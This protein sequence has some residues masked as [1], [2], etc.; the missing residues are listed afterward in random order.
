[1]ALAAKGR[2]LSAGVLLPPSTRGEDADD[3]QF[4]DSLLYHGL[5]LFFRDIRDGDDAFC[6]AP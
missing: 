5:D 4:T 2:L 1:M 3:I 6:L